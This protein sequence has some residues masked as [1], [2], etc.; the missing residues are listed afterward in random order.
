MLPAVAGMNST[1]A[2][3]PAT[4]A[5]STSGQSDTA[6]ALTEPSFFGRPQSFWAISAF[7]AVTVC[8]LFCL[9]VGLSSEKA[10]GSSSGSDSDSEASTA[11][12]DE[13]SGSDPE[14]EQEAR[15][16][17]NKK[18]RCRPA[19]AA[20]PAAA[21]SATDALAPGN[22]GQSAPTAVAASADEEV[23]V[24]G[25]RVRWKAAQA[26]KLAACVF[27]DGLGDASLLIPPPFGELT[28]VGYA[29]V[30]AFT[31]Y[32]M[33]GSKRLAAMGLVKELLPFTDLV[34]LCTICWLL[35]TFFARRRVVAR[36]GITHP[37]THPYEGGLRG[38]GPG[39]PAQ[40]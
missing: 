11:A 37:K 38:P 40:K 23:Q 8:L 9:C 6:E 3:A 5:N 35:E 26:R 24:K 16:R 2:W 14:P 27:L 21:A 22:H 34:P 4:S 25:E 20:A 33:F 19:A 12:S 39:P 28:D 32:M 18:G 30:Y 1:A 7:A 36:L 10:E 15:G 13:D 29:P 31:I 17:L